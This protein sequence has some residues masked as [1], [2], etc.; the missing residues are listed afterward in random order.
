[1]TFE[2]HFD[3]SP[4]SRF[5]VTFFVSLHVS[6]FRKRAKSVHFWVTFELFKQLL[7]TLAR[8]P[9][10]A[11]SKS[12][13]YCLW[14]LW[15]FGVRGSTSG[16][17]MA[18]GSKTDHWMEMR[19]PQEQGW[20]SNSPCLVANWVHFRVGFPPPFSKSVECPSDSGSEKKSL[21]RKP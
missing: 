17:D 15:G 10:V 13:C 16:W 20:P 5:W 8:A 21:L 4:E 12:L 1:M 9:R 2:S 6:G 14:I 18:E 3:R 11:A 19:S 7:V